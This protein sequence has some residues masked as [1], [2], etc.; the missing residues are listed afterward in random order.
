MTV[1]LILVG[2]RRHSDVD[3]SKEGVAAT[4]RWARPRWWV[5]WVDTLTGLKAQREQQEKGTQV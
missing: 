5:W 4:P 1:T 3:N 2:E